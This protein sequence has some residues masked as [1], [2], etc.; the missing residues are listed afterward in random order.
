MVWHQTVC[1]YI[2]GHSPLRF[3]ECLKPGAVVAR[4]IKQLQFPHSA[5]RHM[6]SQAR[7]SGHHSS[8]H[9]RGHYKSGTR[10][11]DRDS[12]FGNESRSLFATFRRA[13]ANQLHL[14]RDQRGKGLRYHLLMTRKKGSVGV[15]VQKPATNLIERLIAEGRAAAPTRSFRDLPP[16]SR[17][18]LQKPLSDILNELREDT[19]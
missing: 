9:G 4:V 15:P 17:V 14:P 13:H 8:R 7:S 3:S 10:K 18:V 2:N 11:R 1:K 5:I 19:V 6:E 12:L 16:P